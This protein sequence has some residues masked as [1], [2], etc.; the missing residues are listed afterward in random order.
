[1]E[2]W[3]NPPVPMDPKKLLKFPPPPGMGVEVSAILT[4]PPVMM[5]AGDDVTKKRSS[6]QHALTRRKLE[7]TEPSRDE[8]LSRPKGSKTWSGLQLKMG[9][10]TKR[11]DDPKEADD[12]FRL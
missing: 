12:G 8:A 7:I 6:A 11:W 10:K 9:V 2:V 3:T 4:M 5:A 1:M